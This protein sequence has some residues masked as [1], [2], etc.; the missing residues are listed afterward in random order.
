MKEKVNLVYTEKIWVGCSL[1]HGRNTEQKQVEMYID[2]E[3]KE[4]G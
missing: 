3:E 1:G 2:D 4:T